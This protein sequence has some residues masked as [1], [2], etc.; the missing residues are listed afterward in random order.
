M[1]LKQLEY[2]LVCAKHASLTKAAEE[3]YTTQPHVSMVIRALEKELGCALFLRK[4]KGVELT[5]EGRRIL[6]YAENAWKNTE[7]IASVCREKTCPCLR[8]ATNSSSYMA[9]LVTGY[10]QSHQEHF[11]LQYTE[12]GIEQMLSLVSEQ[13]YDLGFLFVPDHKRSALLHLL[14]RKRMEFVPLRPV[15][16]VLYVGKGHPLYGQTSITPQKL[17]GLRFIQMEDDFFAVED[18]LYALAGTKGKWRELNRIVQTNSNHM[19]VQMLQGTDLCNLGSYWLKDMYRQYDFGRISVEGFQ[20]KV[21]FGYV[22]HCDR[23]PGALGEEFL[24]FLKTAMEK[25]MQKERAKE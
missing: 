16:M 3:L 25:D 23:G 22:K 5:E 10:Y 7:L 14:E 6:S 24:E 13:E 21:S 2:F 17:L 15:D 12:C 20:G 19:M 9:G 8:I 18:L 1:D 4:S 11:R